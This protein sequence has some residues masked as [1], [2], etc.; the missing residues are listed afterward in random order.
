MV[1]DLYKRFNKPVWVTETA[2]RAWGRPSGKNCTAQENERFIQQIMPALDAEEGVFRYA[3]FVTRDEHEPT[4]D[5][6]LDPFAPNAQLTSVGTA[7]DR[8]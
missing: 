8:V 5:S 1:R 4:G 6:L 7:Y 3:W 2:C